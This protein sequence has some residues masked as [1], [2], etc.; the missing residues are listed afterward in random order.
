M[1]PIRK[2]LKAILSALPY[3]SGAGIALIVAV[4][5]LQIAFIRSHPWNTWVDFL[6]DDAYYY[7][8]VAWNVA[9]NHVSQFR[10]PLL[11]NGYQPLWLALLSGFDLVR[12]GDKIW[13][14]EGAIFL[15]ALCILLAYVLAQRT[16]IVDP[17]AV[18]LTVFCF[19]GVF[20]VGQESVLILPLVLLLVLSRARN[21]RFS[22]VL[23]AA[24]FYA[25]LDAL[26]VLPVFQAYDYFFKKKPLRA[27]LKESLYVVL[28]IVPYFAYNYFRFGVPVPI[29]GMAKSLG[30]VTGENLAALAAYVYV[31]KLPV[32]IVCATW[33]LRRVSQTRSQR[34]TQAIAV[35]LL[36]VHGICA[37][38]YTL[39]SGWPM[40][41]WYY[42]PSAVAT[43]FAISAFLE[44]L[45]DSATAEIVPA[46]QYAAIALLAGMAFFVSRP[47]ALYF[48]GTVH[49]LRVAIRTEKNEQT[50]GN[51]NAILISEFLG[52]RPGPEV[53]AM[54]DRAG[55]LGYFM[56]EK[57]RFIHTEGL[58][59]SKEYYDAMKNGT[60]PEF[61]KKNGV[62]LLI[63]EKEQ[64]LQ[65]GSGPTAQL[66]IVEPSQV[67]SA[68]RGPYMMCF[69]PDAIVYSQTY[70]AEIRYVFQFDKMVPC[71]DE[72]Q[73]KFNG[74]L[75]TYGA[76]RMFSIPDET[77]KR[78]EYKKRLGLPW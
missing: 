74:L 57:D 21:S 62:T 25:R 47:A 56:P 10:A 36:I 35:L 44:A 50:F 38:Y 20:L 7:L 43:V 71:S 46:R 42:W 5:A 32:I 45:H 31:A 26:A 27:A 1:S 23:Y 60:A 40:W 30:S 16:K 77:S 72:L 64:Y 19:V 8:G 48:S 9:H 14:V 12:N 28:L 18:V 61:L 73:T 78:P 41:G 55:S 70:K 34:E 33:I 15:S 52:T 53:I 65:A 66:G 54:G 2:A 4:Q 3:L 39:F 69:P 76:L 29:S 6:V 37:A 59:A 67:L 63:V 75:G 24:L 51:R 22:P 58:V 49:N 68:R 13:L 17:L 11:T